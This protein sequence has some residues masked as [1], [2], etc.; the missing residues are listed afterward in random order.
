MAKLDGNKRLGETK[1]TIKYPQKF[2]LPNPAQF[3][4]GIITLKDGNKF[5]KGTKINVAYNNNGNPYEYEV[6][7]EGGEQTLFG[8]SLSGNGK[9]SDLDK[10]LK[11]ENQEFKIKITL[12]GTATADTYTV[13]IKTGAFKTDAI[14]DVTP[15]RIIGEEHEVVISDYGKEN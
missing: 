8:I 15:I 2:A 12:P 13:V 11:N 10:L 5:P 9:H 14:T 4:D 6:K 3:I 7:A 1:F